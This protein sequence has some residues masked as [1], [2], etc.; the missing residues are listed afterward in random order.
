MQGENKLQ[1]KA[2]MV[3]LLLRLPIDLSDLIE[4]EDLRAGLHHQDDVVRC[5]T[6][7]AL[8]K[9]FDAK[10]LA[11]ALKELEV[12]HPLPSQFF[13]GTLRHILRQNTRLLWDRDYRRL[14]QGKLEEFRRLQQQ[15]TSD[16]ESLGYRHSGWRLGMRIA[17]I[18]E[19][20]PADSVRT[21]RKSPR[22][23]RLPYPGALRWERFELMGG[24]WL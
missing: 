6:L 10:G 23:K 16:A 7:T 2:D 5:R 1:L 24:A 12:L 9:L 8:H 14:L 13:Q 11:V 3:E 19:T 22:R 15:D 17:A 18:F 4:P 20:G 21:W